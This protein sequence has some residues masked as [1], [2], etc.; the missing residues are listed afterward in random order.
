MAEHIKT[1]SE[2]ISLPTFEERFAYVTNIKDVGSVT[3]GARRYLNQIFYKSRE[4]RSIR[5]RII[6][7]DN[8]NDLAVDGYQ[9]KGP[10]YIHHL[11]ELTDQD[12][13]E[14]SKYLT[15]PEFLVCTSFDTHNAVH[16]GSEPA[17]YSFTERTPND[18]CPWK[19]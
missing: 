17:R 10:I 13:L 18:T 4:W 8:G 19:T 16:Y 15:D 5:D 14:R 1:Y 2:L 6:L 12:I 9:I 11:K 3:F 7:R